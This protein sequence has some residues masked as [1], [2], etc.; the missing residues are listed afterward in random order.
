MIFNYLRVFIQNIKRNPVFSLLSI[1]GLS[2]GIGIS[3]IIAL[4]TFDEL[5]YDRFHRD[6]DRI[7]RVGIS[8]I[9][10]GNKF[11]G[12]NTCA[13]MAKALNTEVPGIEQSIRLGQW[14]SLLVHI[15]EEP[16]AENDVLLADREFFEF[17][18]FKLIAGDPVTALKDKNSIV[19]TEKL[20]KKYY[21]ND[22][23]DEIVGR[24]LVVGNSEQ[25]Y[26]ITGVAE[27]APMNSH[28][29]FSMILSISSWDYSENPQWTSNSL[30]TYF[31]AYP[32]SDLNEIQ[33][34]L[35]QLVEK[36]VGPEIRQ[37]L[38]I[39]LAEFREGGGDYGYWIQPLHDIHLKSHYDGELEANGDI[40][41]VLIFSVVGLFVLIVAGTNFVNLS[42]ARATD[43]AKEVGIRKSVGAYRRQL[44][45]QHLFESFSY[46]LIAGIIALVGVIFGLDYFN[47][48]TG[49]DFALPDVFTLN[50]LLYFLLFVVLISVLSGIYPALILSSYQPI[51][52]LKGHIHASAG[53]LNA[54]NLMV[55][56]QF[57]LTTV[58]IILT[59]TIFKQ[60]DMMRNKNLGFDKDKIM[61]VFNANG[62]SNKETFKNEVLAVPEVRS[63]NITQGFPPLIYN[64]SVFRFGDPQ[65]DHLL[66]FYY[67]DKDHFETFRF[68]LK[69]GRAF[70]DEELD[71]NSVVI[72]EAAF[73]LSGWKDLDNR[74]IFE[75]E[76][77]GVLQPFNVIGVVQDFHFQDFK[78]S[79]KPMAFF[80]GE[81]GRFITMK[82]ETD[83]ILN[84]VTNVENRWMELSNG[85]PFDYSFVDS[86][87][88]KLFES[89]KRLGEL[90]SILAILTII[91][92]SL[93][94]FG[95]AAYVARSKRKEFSIRKV[96]GASV[97]RVMVIQIR[98]F[99]TIA[100]LAMAVA[101]P[102][103]FWLVQKWLNGFEYRTANDWTI[104]T[105]T[106]AAVMILILVTVGYQ[107]YKASTLSP[108]KV[109]REE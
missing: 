16:I 88:D 83:D 70:T 19:L 84:T 14:P 100:I 47:H 2:L 69:E 98:Y 30:Y 37:Y 56:F 12:V 21:G 15:G 57:A 68:Q 54:R 81:R 31:K 38:G 6:S 89:E 17:F 23:Y 104:Y 71:E 93:G 106:V 3:Y 67:T 42:T 8:G 44:I 91:T 40:Q 50:Y 41:N 24:I 33:T 34:Q 61:V 77:E 105:A 18:D 27:E 63:V 80:C 87:F 43:R 86:Q 74:Q 28:F 109:L 26:E 101:I 64:N 108:T 39:S 45:F 52:I 85:K 103:S 58:A 82:L 51:S 66:Y 90:T 32:E 75:F 96:L 107:S 13:P 73:R 25:S 20:A 48:I 78:S 35:D 49:K 62:L 53:K 97:L 99:V 59:I 36:Y 92:A 55:G 9:L 5:S 4:Y 22:S 76:D 60:L 1:L 46:C 94:L 72:N 29:R 11:D 7:Y 95:L 65:E 102:A 79:I 10:S